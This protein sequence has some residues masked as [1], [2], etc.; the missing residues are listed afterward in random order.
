MKRTAC[1]ISLLVLLTGTAG[2]A[3]FWTHFAN[4]LAYDAGTH[5]GAIPAEFQSVRLSSSQVVHLSARA[6]SQALPSASR[7][8]PANTGLAALPCTFTPEPEKCF[9]NIVLDRTF[10]EVGFMQAPGFSQKFIMKIPPQLRQHADEGNPPPRN[11]PAPAPCRAAM[12]SIPASD[13]HRENG[14]RLRHAVLLLP[15]NLRGT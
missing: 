11:P 6:F 5:S 14:R 1:I 10:S 7:R 8:L 3:D 13:R 4:D 15:R 9:V 2:A 12:H